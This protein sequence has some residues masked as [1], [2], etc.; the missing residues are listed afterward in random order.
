MIHDVNDEDFDLE[1]IKSEKPVL[2]CFSAPWCGPCRMLQEAVDQ[3]SKRSSNIK[4]CKINIDDNPV[5]PSKYGI[6]SIPVMMLFKSGEV[7]DSK[8]GAHAQGTIEEWIENKL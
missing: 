8:L 1:V 2:V 3:V 5:I 6:R 4:V 7:V